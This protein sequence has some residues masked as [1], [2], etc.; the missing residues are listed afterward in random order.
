MESWA[1]PG[2]EAML[3]LLYA[4][5]SYSKSVPVGLFHPTHDTITANSQ[6]DDY[7]VST[8]LSTCVPVFGTL[9]VEKYVAEF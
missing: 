2:N 1:G 8:Y 9:R 4:H 5:S 6:D 7:A 3:T